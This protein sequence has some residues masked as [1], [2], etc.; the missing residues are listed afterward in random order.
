[1]KGK[2]S[3]AKIHPGERGSQC[4]ISELFHALSQPV[5][6]LCCALAVSAKKARGRELRRDLETA[7]EQAEL[8]AKR[9]DV[10][11]ERVEECLVGTEVPRSHHGHSGA[12]LSSGQDFPIPSHE[13]KTGNNLPV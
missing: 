1:M 10:L 8:V 5:T 6:T 13:P 9:M 2:K 12:S 4:E 7:R 3:E 11:R